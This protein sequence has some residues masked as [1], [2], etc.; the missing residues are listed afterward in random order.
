MMILIL[1]GAPGVGKGTQGQRLAER[2]SIPRIS[3]G[4]MFRDMAAAGTPLG[5]KAR[6][7]FTRG[8][9]VP[10]EVVIGVVEER[11]TQSDCKNGFLF[12]GFPR[13]VSQADALEAMLSRRGLRLDGV[14][15]LVVS[16]E[17]LV[18]RLSGRRTCGNCGA[19]Y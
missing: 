12:D 4:D 11:I 8:E 17:E 19:I 14:L 7:Y 3:T 9:L 18:R 10:D 2:L 15:D 13:T 6:E 16:E 5:L 1:L